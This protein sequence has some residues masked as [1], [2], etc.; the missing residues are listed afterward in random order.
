MLGR[1]DSGVGLEEAH[2][3]ANIGREEGE[4]CLGGAD[5]VLGLEVVHVMED[6]RKR[7]MLGQGERMV[8]LC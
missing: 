8:G 5:S 7:E 4:E 1:V 3:F 2:M 6:M